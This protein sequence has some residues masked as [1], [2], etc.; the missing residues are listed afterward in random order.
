MILFQD[1][2]VLILSK[3]EN[4]LSVPGLASPDN[5]LDRVKQLHPSALVVHRLDMAT[6]GIMVFALNKT[7]QTHLAKQFEARTIKKKYIAVVHGCLKQQYGEIQAPLLCDWENRPKQ[8]VDWC[9]GKLALTQYEVN[10]TNQA[11][12]TTRVTL[13][14]HTGR[15]HQLRV[16]MQQL[17][18]PI[19][20]DYFYAPQE[21]YG[22]HKRLLLHA[23]EI[24]LH[25]PSSN[26]RATFTNPSPF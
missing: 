23:E 14:P 19:V 17:G 20:G 21:I 2:D 24:S 15:S 25:L 5:L 3:P 11:K 12:Q 22:T 16:H 26:A 9:K 10:S 7:S 6:S 13:Y 1:D 8:K 18:N 4:I